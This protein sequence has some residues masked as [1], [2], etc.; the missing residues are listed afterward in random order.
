MFVAKY[1]TQPAGQI[2]YLSLFEEA[3]R[4]LQP[5]HIDAA[6]A[7]GTFGGARKLVEL[8]DAWNAGVWRNVKKRWLVGIDW[9]RSEPVALEYLASCP[10]AT[11]RVP[12]G[13][14]VVARRGCTPLVP[15][16]PKAFM[17]RA[18][19]GIA[20]I[21]GSG[22]LSVNGLTRGHECGSLLVFRSPFS[23]KERTLLS[24]ATHLQ[25]W[26]NASWRSAS[27]L[28]SLLAAY[29][30]LYESAENLQVPVPT[31]DDAAPTSRAARGVDRRRAS[32]PDRLKK[33]RAAQNLWIEAGVLSRNR[34]PANPGNQLMM[35]PMT[36]V[37]FGFPAADVVPNTT[38]GQ[39]AIDYGGTIRND[40]SLRFSDNSMDVLGLPIPG[41]GGPPSYDR[42]RLRFE[43]YANG[44]FRLRLGTTVDLRS[45]R[46]RSHAIGADFKMSSGRLWGVY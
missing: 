32:A 29:R 38:I 15:F 20:L 27:E 16:H 41:A 26:F 4:H 9:F 7:Y 18:S 34:G 21:S 14:V 24:C 39:V 13:S 25:G 46:N 28:G 2:E 3:L 1:V 37:F 35:S 19:N 30:T 5:T 11:V 42:Q 17:M 22:N 8:F 40:C 44:T 23:Q 36:R 12:N 33:L 43:K 6:V 45:W 31:D 10:R